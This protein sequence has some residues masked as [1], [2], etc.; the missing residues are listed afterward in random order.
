M[1]MRLAIYVEFYSEIRKYVNEYNYKIFKTILL[2]K[3]DIIP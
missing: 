2:G 3:F 1:K